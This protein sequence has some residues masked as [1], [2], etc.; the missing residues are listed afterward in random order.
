[1]KIVPVEQAIGLTL[2]HD[3]TEIVPTISKGAVFRKGHVVKAEDIP[4]LQR[5][6]KEH[7]FVWDESTDL[8]HENDAAKRIAQVI[9]GQG[10]CFSEP[11]EGKVAFTSTSQGFFQLNIE[12]LEELNSIEHVSIATIHSMQGVVKGRTLGAT[13]VIPLAVPEKTLLAVESCC[14]DPLFSVLPFTSHHFGI[15]VTGAE[16]FHGRVQDAFIPF[17]RKKVDVWG[18]DIAFTTIVPD[19]TEKTVAAIHDAIASGADIV[20]VTGGMS[21]DPDDKT[22]AA[23]KCIADEVITYGT[24]VY[25][26]A[27]FMLAYKGNIPIM[28]LPGGVMYSKASILDI[29]MP[30]ILAGIRVCKQD[31]VKLGHGGLCENC[32]Q[33]HYPQCGFGI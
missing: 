24:P 33:C 9:S 18:S 27:M 23:I 25:P 11:V 14:K 32:S 26:G 6:G 19:E 5:I 15:V 28:G 8:I 16:V 30:R 13:R 20:T 31:I 29:L 12:L 1:M 21:V 2:C 17:L 10:I 4:T 3:I 7:L 22:P